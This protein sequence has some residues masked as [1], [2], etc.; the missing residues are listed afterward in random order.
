MIP[1]RDNLRLHLVWAWSQQKLS[2]T[3]L[4]SKGSRAHL[5]TKQGRGALGCRAELKEHNTPPAKPNLLALP[6]KSHSFYQRTGIL[7]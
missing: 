1:Q 7:L 3:L 2:Q 6:S 5:R 4:V